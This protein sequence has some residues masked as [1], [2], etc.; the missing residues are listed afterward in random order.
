VTSEV[1]EADLWPAFNVGSRYVLQLL[2][3]CRLRSNS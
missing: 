2:I 3:F 1:D